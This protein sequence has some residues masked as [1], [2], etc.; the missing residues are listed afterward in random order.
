MMVKNE[1]CC[2]MGGLDGSTS[3]IESQN[4]TSIKVKHT[5]TKSPISRAKQK[6]HNKSPAEEPI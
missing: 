6:A 5:P 4:A 2:Q 3:T 1:E